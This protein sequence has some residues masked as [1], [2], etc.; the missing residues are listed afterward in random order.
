MLDLPGHSLSG[1]P[2]ASHT[3]SWYAQTISAW[4]EAIGVPRAFVCGHSFGGRIGQ[5]MPRGQ[6]APRRSPSSLS[7]LPFQVVVPARGPPAAAKLD[8]LGP[9]ASGTKRTRCVCLWADNPPRMACRSVWPASFGWRGA[10]YVGSA[11]L[12]VTRSRT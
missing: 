5:C 3:L 8:A 11:S 1:Q 4:A 6:A 10:R 9:N 7:R 12:L 2:N